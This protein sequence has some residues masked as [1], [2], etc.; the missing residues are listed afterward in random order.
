MNRYL[1]EISSS[2]SAW[3]SI[4]LDLSSRRLIDL[5]F[6]AVEGLSTD[7]LKDE[8]KRAV[9]GPRTWSP[10]SLDRPTL[11][12]QQTVPLQPHSRSDPSCA[13]HIIA[14]VKQPGE[15]GNFRGTAIQCLD[16]RTGR[17][18]W[19]WTRPRH[20]ILLAKFDFRGPSAAVVAIA[21]FDE[22]VFRRVL[23][24]QE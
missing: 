1:R 22:F 15:G 4:I 5:P 14:Y 8:V 9:A 20:T 11:L 24:R 12:R 19:N 16:G 2:R 6:D 21:S 23:M 13:A 7:A 10:I 18:L 3:L 17:L